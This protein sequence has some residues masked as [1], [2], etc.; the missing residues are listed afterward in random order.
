MPTCLDPQ[1]VRSP[2]DV[3]KFLQLS[4]VTGIAEETVLNVSCIAEVQSE[5][6]VLF[7]GVLSPSN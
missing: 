3:V 7:C 1:S 6:L 5:V 2:L 4:L